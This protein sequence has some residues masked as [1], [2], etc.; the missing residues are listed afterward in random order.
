MVQNPYSP[1]CDLTA[2]VS[3]FFFTFLS[4]KER[5]SKLSNNTN[6]YCSEWYKIVHRPW[7]FFLEKKKGPLQK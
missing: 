1:F 3:V 7:A 6:K 5:R 4:L 2:S